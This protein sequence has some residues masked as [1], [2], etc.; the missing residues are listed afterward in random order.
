M[1]A[2]PAAFIARIIDSS[3]DW[4]EARRPQCRRVLSRKAEAQTCESH[5]REEQPTRVWLLEVAEREPSGG[6]RRQG[7]RPPFLRHILRRVATIAIVGAAT[8]RNRQRGIDAGAAAPHCV[9]ELVAPDGSRS[10]GST[11]AHS[12]SVRTLGLNA[13]VCHEL[14]RLCA[15]SIVILRDDAHQ[16][17]ATLLLA[18][19]RPLENVYEMTSRP[20]GCS[21]QFVSVRRSLHSELGADP[22]TKMAHFDVADPRSRLSLLA[23]LATICADRPGV[24]MGAL[25]FRSPLYAHVAQIQRVLDLQLTETT[26]AKRLSIAPVTL[27]RWFAREGDVCPCHFFQWLRLHALARRIAESDAASARISESLGFANGDSV[28]RSLKRLSGL[29]ISE[30]RSEHGQQNFRHRMATALE[31]RFAHA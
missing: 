8:I 27:R 6:M 4:K 21:E 18:E 5:Q 11:M 22:I 23:W 17:N 13:S 29:T 19:V 16:E 14:S 24:T 2:D 30:L 20:T 26:L 12:I 7:C 15:P 9:R 3:P 1:H 31:G 25:R 10:H 28:R